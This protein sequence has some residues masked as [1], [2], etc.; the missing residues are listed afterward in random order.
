L[1][2]KNNSLPET[3]QPSSFSISEVINWR[4]APGE[5][6]S[7][8]T[9]S[10]DGKIIAFTSTKTGTKNIWIKQL[11]GGE[12]VQITK[13]EFGNQHPIWSPDGDEIAFYSAR[14]GTPGIW[15]ISSFGG[16]PSFIKTIEDGSMVLKYWSKKGSIYY[17]ANRNLHALDIK[18]GLSSQLTD[19]SAAKVNPN[20]ITI[21]P[22]EK[23][24][25]YIAFENEQYGVW[26]MPVQYGAS[27]KQVVSVSNEIRNPVWHPDSER[28]IYSMNVGGVFQVF[29]VNINGGQPRQV[30]FGD[31]NRKFFTAR[32]RK[33]RMSGA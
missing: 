4:S 30:T 21:S 17:E 9:I 25:A 15:R 28:I 2:G 32:Q 26:S 24:V 8:G 13:D 12:A 27:P 5:V 1:T 29:A 33:N 14:S 10:P 18:S 3:N 11:S 6:Y 7:A 22:D 23:R 19:F 31:K 20:T 16:T